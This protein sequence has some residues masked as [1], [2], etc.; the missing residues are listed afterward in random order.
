MNGWSPF[1]ICFSSGLFVV[2]IQ[3][4]LLSVWRNTFSEVFTIQ[5]VHTKEA[6]SNTWLINPFCFRMLPP[7]LKKKK[8]EEMPNDI[9]DVLQGEIARLDQR[10]KVCVSAEVN[11]YW[12]CRTGAS[13]STVYGLSLISLLRIFHMQ[14]PRVILA[15]L[16]GTETSVLQRSSV[17]FQDSVHT[18]QRTDFV[19]L[20]ETI[21]CLHAGSIYYR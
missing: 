10:F 14:L 17:T 6:Y 21:K 1:F 9:P 18:M 4:I 15:A 8:V 20:I 16:S 3:Q 11:L 13:I 2:Y 5:V 12:L 19:M 7:P